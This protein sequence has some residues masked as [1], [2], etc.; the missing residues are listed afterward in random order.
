MNQK[1]H[2]RRP[3]TVG[4]FKKC[5]EEQGQTHELAAAGIV[6]MSAMRAGNH[7]TFIFFRFTSFVATLDTKKQRETKRKT[8]WE[9]KWETREAGRQGKH[10]LG[11]ADTTS[12]EGTQEGRRAGRQ[13]GRQAG[14]HGGPGFGKADTPSNKGKQ[15]GVQWETR[16]DKTSGRWT[17]HPTKGSKKED[18]L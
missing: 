12:N 5:L 13:T 9:T 8:S 4:G 6:K 16:G 14:K 1:L 7:F 15:Q 2:H 3:Q 17:H 10:G 11:K 18:K